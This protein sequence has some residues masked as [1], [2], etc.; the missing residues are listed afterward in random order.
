MNAAS[1]HLLNLLHLGLE[2]SLLIG[3][4]LLCA[5]NSGNLGLQT[6]DDWPELARRG[7][8]LCGPWTP[9]VNYP[10]PFFMLGS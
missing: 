8:N 2:V 3:A 7:R 5:G 4:T 10:A 9:V 6:T 1:L